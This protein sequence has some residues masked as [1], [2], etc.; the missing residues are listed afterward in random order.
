MTGPIYEAMLAGLCFLAMYFVRFDVDDD[1][2]RR[3]NRF[4]AD[5]AR[6]ND[7]SDD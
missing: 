6:N 1:V 5:G 4:R 3:R 2:N 7:A